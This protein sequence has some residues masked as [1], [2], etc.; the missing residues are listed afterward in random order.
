M[1]DVCTT[2]DT[3]HIDTILKFLPHTR[4]N[5]G[6]STFF[7]AAMISVFRSVR[8]RR[9]FLCVLCM[10]CTFAQLP[11]SLVWYSNTQNNLSSK[12]LFSHYIHSHRLAAEMWTMMKNNLL[13]K[14]IF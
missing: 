5:M 1:F 8:S 2:G 13:G 9:R 7:T 3:A 12:R 11:N 10:K 14:K 6:A 4:V